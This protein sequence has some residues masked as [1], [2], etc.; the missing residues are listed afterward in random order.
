MEEGG[1]GRVGRAEAGERNEAK[2]SVKKKGN[3][4]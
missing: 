4:K 1:G 2:E 3:K